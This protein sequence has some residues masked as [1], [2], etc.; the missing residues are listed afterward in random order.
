[1][2]KNYQKIQALLKMTFES[3]KRYYETAE[4]IQIVE[5]KRFLN[6][7]SVER[8]KYANELVE[9]FTFNEI[10]P[11][12]LFIKKG[13]QKHNGLD[14]KIV[15]EN[16]KYLPIVRKCLNYDEDIIEKCAMLVRDKSIP[17]DILEVITRLMTFLIFQGI[18][19]N[20]IIEELKAKNNQ[21]Y[22]TK[23]VQLRNNF[24]R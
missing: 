13:S 20:H 4:D 8:N 1:M 10:E 16:S 2:K 12:M 24:L 23:V 19:G 3:E 9:A 17:V 22:Q 7:Q 21:Q 5:L 6:H 18:E 14:L 15:L 11:E